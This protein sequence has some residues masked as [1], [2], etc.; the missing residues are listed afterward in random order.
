MG[1]LPWTKFQDFYLRLGFLKVLVAALSPQRR[2]ALN[3]VVYRKLRSPLFQSAYHYHRPLFDRTVSQVNWY[4]KEHNEGK[5]EKP[6]VAECLLVVAD[7]PSL[8]FAVTEPTA[9]KI[10]DWG[11]NIGLVG[12][13]NQITERGLLLRTLLPSTEAEQFLS[14]DVTTWNPFVLSMQERLFF[15]FHLGEIDAVTTN[16]IEELSRRDSDG[17]IESPDAAKVTC[18]SLFKM[19]NGSR[20]EVQFRDFAAYRIARDL[21]CVIAGELD[22]ADLLKDCGGARR[23]LPKPPKRIVKRVG[24]RSPTSLN[25]KTTKNADHQTV[26][27]FEQLVDLGFVTKPREEHSEKPLSLDYRRRWRYCRTGA[28]Q[29][30]AKSLSRREPSSGHFQWDGFA[31][32]AADALGLAHDNFTVP[33]DLELG[34]YIWRAYQQVRRPIGMTP[35]DS[36]ALLAMINSVSEGMPIE[37]TRFHKLVLRIKQHSELPE[38][39]F[40]ASGNDLDHMFVLLKPGFLEALEHSIAESSRKEPI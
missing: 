38:H 28:C 1:K 15:L 3:E 31:H 19:L 5:Y 33:T 9:Y 14:G 17:P 35:F 23:R 7:C 10:L 40:F 26:P 12:R 20:D 24:A 2:S 25:R 21:A 29:A 11:H 37:M 13:G 18:R 6:S 16:I 39:A 32:A 27:R 30:W 22:L 36:V 34:R 8:L 4:G